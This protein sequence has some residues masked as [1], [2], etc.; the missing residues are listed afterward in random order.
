[1]RRDSTKLLLKCAL[2]AS[3][4]LILLSLYLLFDPFKVIRHYKDFY[5]GHDRVILNRD[6]VS[7]E[8]WLQQSPVEHYDSFILGS[9]R[10]LAYHCAD[11]AEFLPPG[12]RPFH[13]DASG[14][15]LYGI[16]SKA[17]FL[18]ARNASMQDVLFVVDAETLLGIDDMDRHL[19]VKH[20][21]VSGRGWIAFHS[22][23]FK[24]F[25]TDFF[26]SYLDWRFTG[27]YRGYMRP[28]LDD[29]ILTHIDKTNDLVFTSADDEIRDRGDG[30]WS[31]RPSVF[32]ARDEAHLA[33]TESVVGDT[34]RAMLDELRKIF[35]RRKSRYRVVV[36]PLY[37]M[38]PLAATDLAALREIL[39]AENV[40][41]F[42]GPNDLTRDIHHYYEASHYRPEVART[43][44]KRIYQH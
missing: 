19:Y 17:K 39:G 16:W 22:L 20:P 42:S 25:V 7:T 24:A 18:D 32:V 43:I 40:F 44:M 3:P 36:N 4:L 30:Y 26:V 33:P 37:D 14:E 6:Y 5:V 27:A 8:I 11:W 21:L 12:A 23:F 1:M 31:A 13:F 41:D 9:S 34:Q 28:Y 38:R 29:R 10:S 15:T 35:D 2:I